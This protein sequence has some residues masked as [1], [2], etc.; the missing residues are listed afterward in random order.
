MSRKVTVAV[1]LVAGVAIALVVA[2]LQQDSS[3]RTTILEGIVDRD[4]AIRAEAWSLMGPDPGRST[5]IERLLEHRDRPAV[6]ADAAIEFDRRDWPNEAV[7]VTAAARLGDHRP[8]L[9]HL[10]RTRPDD[11]ESR[12]QLLSGV[13]V[14]MAEADPPLG[15]RLLEACLAWLSPAERSRLLEAVVEAGAA[16]PRLDRPLISMALMGT[17]PPIASPEEPATII[18][19]CIATGEPPRTAEETRRLPGWTLGSPSLASW[20]RLEL[21]RRADDGDVEARRTLGTLDRER[22]LANAGAVAGDRS[23]S[24][25]RRTISA[26]RLVEQGRTP[27][28][29]ALLN[30]LAAGPSDADG[31]VHA[32]IVIA[33]RGLSETARRGLE[34]RW[35]RSTEEAELRAGLL[36]AAM[37][38]RDDEDT[39]E[40]PVRME[41]D[42]LARES[43]TSPRVRRAARLVARATERWP[44][45]PADLE[46][47]AYAARTRRLEDGRYDPDAILL[48]LLAEDPEAARILVSRPEA[49]AVDAA[50]FAREISWRRVLAGAFRPHWIDAVGEPV[51]GD[52]DALRL[53]VDL[54]AATRLT[55]P[56]AEPASSGEDLRR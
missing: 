30:L 53:W 32:S 34:A 2:S 39:T 28:D 3:R 37:R 26:A 47:E 48:G 4:P 43:G 33:H 25:E 6:L 56:F 15:E 46:A 22:L 44:F 5:V 8:L 31:S 51:P 50:T 49:P 35:L 38:L 36:L 16:A 10:D 1:V 52:E 29:A 40:D 9:D 11:V 23:A 21:Q 24:F 13:A 54:L 17:P 45:A 20:G 12:E 42:R 27:G 41:I 19:R 14:V 55:E 7:F 18:A